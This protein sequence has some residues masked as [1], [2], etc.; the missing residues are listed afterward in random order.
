MTSPKQA[1]S[2]F[3]PPFPLLIAVVVFVLAALSLMYPMLSGQIVGGSDQI[4]VGYALRDFAARS[5]QQTGHIPQWNPFIFGGMPLWEVPGHFDVFY[6]TPAWL[7]WF[8]RADLVLT[9]SFFIHLVVAG[10]AMYSLLRT[11]RASWTASV[12]AGLSYDLPGILASMLSPGHDGKLFASALVP[13]AFVALIRAI[14]GGKIWI[15]RLGLR[16]SSASSC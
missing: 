2:K 16:S 7:R 9:L 10:I 8:L 1:E 13:F 5:M 11:L 12:V 6:P 3:E 15:V 14:R 4:N